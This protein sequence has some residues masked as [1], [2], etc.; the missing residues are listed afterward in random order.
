MNNNKYIARIK[1]ATKL[2]KN[3]VNNNIRLVVHRTARHIYAQIISANNKVLVTAST[4][5]KCHKKTLLYTGNIKSATLIGQLIAIKAIKK[6]ITKL[7]F[8][9]SGYKFHGRIKS[10]AIAARN[11][12]LNF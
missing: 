6:G 8:D 10:L 9:R 12:G 3:L 5:E 4:L 7:T 2:R 11:N 1:R